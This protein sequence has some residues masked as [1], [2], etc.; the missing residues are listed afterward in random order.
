M[1][2]RPDTV[3]RW[4]AGTRQR[5]AWSWM[6]RTGVMISLVLFSG[7][8]PRNQ[9]EVFRDP[10]SG[11]PALFVALCEGEEVEAFEV[12]IEGAPQGYGVLWRVERGPTAPT[13][14]EVVLGQVPAGFDEVVGL[15]DSTLT[16][17]VEFNAELRG[18]GA[19]ETG[20]SFHE[21]SLSDISA[22]QIADLQ[23]AAT[24][25]C[26]KIPASLPGAL[27][28]LAPVLLIGVVLGTL[29]VRAAHHL[30]PRVGRR[31][32]WRWSFGFAVIGAGVLLLPWE[33]GTRSEPLRFVGIGA[34]LGLVLVVCALIGRWIRRSE[35]TRSKVIEAL[36]VL[37]T[38]LFF[39]VPATLF[40]GMVEGGILECGEG[41]S[42]DCSPS[43]LDR[44]VLLAPLAPA[45]VTAVLVGE[46]GWWVAKRPQEGREGR[47]AG[48]PP[49][50]R[51]IALGVLLLIGL[52][53]TLVSAGGAK[54]PPP[55]LVA[56]SNVCE[57]GLVE[58]L[59]A[60][61]ADP[62]VKGS[63]EDMPEARY[64]IDVAAE[65][66]GAPVIK[67][68]LD[69]GASTE[70]PAEHPPLLTAVEAGN[71]V[72]VEVLVEA[73][74]DPGWVSSDGRTLVWTAADDGQAEIV[75]V[76][77]QAGAPVNDADDTHSHTPLFRA[78]MGGHSDA[79]KNL[80]GAGAD[81]DQRSELSW[82]DI[83]MY[84]YSLDEDEQAWV[85]G[86]LG[87]ALGL[88]PEV[89]QRFEPGGMG[90]AVTM[91]DLVPDPSESVGSFP[92]L[93]LAAVRGDIGMVEVLL[94]AGADPAAGTE[95]TGHLPGEA[96]E[97]LGYE[98][99]A[100]LLQPR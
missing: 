89:L 31:S 80:L 66:C 82:I 40:A 1:N 60:A 96:A 76:L 38:A 92:P 5:I 84:V 81:P 68:L 13:V 74:A 71:V 47:P 41:W 51:A 46:G 91:L 87:P 32:V 27:N 85:V 58:D 2:R 23:A 22:E 56:A 44:V 39:V 88:D 4:V 98:H 79:A 54:E 65:H 43:W 67:A 16:R 50:K 10:E 7:C 75:D 64:P 18:G 59:L 26:E 17:S 9:G 34:V 63:T 36:L 20:E 99:V 29:R 94:A 53:A 49:V 69:A 45:W 83:G 62:D 100:A 77:I 73:G 95:P 70:L 97:V 30:P 42:F 19:A 57:V 12:A 8:S 14:D 15:A 78:V 33:N 24:G 6:A 37:V 61:G 35:H 72:A 3:K 52:V 93:Y 28:S 21:S 90:E 25:N 48:H 86:S 55:D 11:R